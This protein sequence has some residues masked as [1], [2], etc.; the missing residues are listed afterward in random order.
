VCCAWQSIVNADVLTV[1]G[2]EITSR[3]RRK[4]KEEDWKAAT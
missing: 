2:G 1:K 4:D 3:R